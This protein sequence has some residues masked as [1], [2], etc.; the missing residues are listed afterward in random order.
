MGAGMRVPLKL[1]GLGYDLFPGK[2]VALRG[3]NVSGE[4]F[5][6]TEV[7]SMPLV[8]LAAST[9]EELDVH[10]TRLTGSDGETRPLSEEE[11]TDVLILTGPFLDLEHPAIA[12]GDLEQYLPADTKIQPDR[13][14]IQDV[15]RA[16][17]S[18]PL[19]R[20]LKPF[21]Q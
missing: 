8:P 10:T 20:L 13:A 15:F 17:I 6:V 9:P 3:S 12:S 5:A 4:Y 21:P 2:I 16:L 19:Q 1:D 14:T 18:Q 7:L 11:K